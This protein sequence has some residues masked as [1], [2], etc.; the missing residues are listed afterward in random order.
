MNESIESNENVL[1]ILSGLNTVIDIINF[2]SKLV[3]KYPQSTLKT[4]K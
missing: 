2:F 1:E 4:Q 3:Q